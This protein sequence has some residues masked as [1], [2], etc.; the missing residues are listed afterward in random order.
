MK[1]E[2]ISLRVAPAVAMMGAMFL[3][4]G[5]PQLKAQDDDDRRHDCHERIEHARERAQ[6]AA[7]QFGNDSEQAEHARHELR[8]S[9]ERCGEMEGDQRYGDQQQ[10]RRE[11]DDGRYQDQ[12]QYPQGQDPQGG[13]PHA[14]GFALPRADP[15]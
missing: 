3:F 4:A 14:E 15:P 12:R 7:S 13:A 2:K 8:E 6:A 9:R 5:T 1:F 10:Y 11:G